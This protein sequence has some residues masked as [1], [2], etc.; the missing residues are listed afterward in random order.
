MVRRRK[1][2]RDQKI[3]K[4][5]RIGIIKTLRLVKVAQRIVRRIF[6]IVRQIQMNRNFLKSGR[7]KEFDNKK[8]LL[9]ILALIGDSAKFV[10]IMYSL[11][12]KQM[13]YYQKYYDMSSIYGTKNPT[14]LKNMARVMKRRTP[15]SAR[16][17]MRYKGRR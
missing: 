10:N 1:Q 3:P 17:L 11:M 15:S 7:V 13:E 5:P 8:S 2:Y 4:P 14:H 12:V 16:T 9:N 6:F